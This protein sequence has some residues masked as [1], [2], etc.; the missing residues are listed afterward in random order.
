MPLILASIDPSLT[1]TAI[2]ILDAGTND[3]IEILTLKVPKGVMG[4]AR[5]NWLCKAVSSVLKKHNPTEVFIEGYSYMSKGRS[6]VDLGE[7]GGLYRMILARRWA[8]YYEIPP[9]SLKKFITGKGNAKKQI[10]L[11]QTFR[12]WG[13]GSEILTDDNQVDAY[14]LARFGA[15]FLKWNQGNDNFTHYE[16]EAL[17]G[18]K[19]KCT[20]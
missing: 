16:I 5:L 4:I 13:L 9:T 14:G 3:I 17:K 18:L 2:C 12:K 20:L 7:L 19:A 11:E 1:G 15:A 8:G 6:I 10:L